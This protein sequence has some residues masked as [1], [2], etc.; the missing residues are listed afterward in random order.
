MASPA[1][2]IHTSITWDTVLPETQEG[3][4]TGEKEEQAETRQKGRLQLDRAHPAQT[5]VGPRPQCWDFVHNGETEGVSENFENGWLV[6][7]G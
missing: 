5:S 3:A 7:S 6:H 1:S 2:F 4:L